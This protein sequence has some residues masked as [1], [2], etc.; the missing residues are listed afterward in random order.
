MKQRLSLYHGLGISQGIGLNLRQIGAGMLIVDARTDHATD[1]LADRQCQRIEGLSA[2]IRIRSDIQ[3]DGCAGGYRMSPLHIERRLIVARLT[4]RDF[5]ISRND[6]DLGRGNFELF[7]ENIE[8]G[9]RWRRG[10]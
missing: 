6:L 5:W 2:R 10:R 4:R 7:S 8:H 3:T 1:I 9:R